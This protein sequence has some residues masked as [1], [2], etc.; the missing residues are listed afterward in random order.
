ML[1]NSFEVSEFLYKLLLFPLNIIW[2][3]DLPI[4]FDI[5]TLTEILKE[6]SNEC[7]INKEKIH[8]KALEFIYTQKPY[9]NINDYYLNTTVEKIYEKEINNVNKVT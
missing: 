8:E 6:N 7:I 5:N 3:K 1:R 4:V 2:Q 9:E